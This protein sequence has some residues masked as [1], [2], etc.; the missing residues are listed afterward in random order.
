MT[1]RKVTALRVQ[2][3][4]K[5]R[6]NVFLDGEYAFAVSLKSAA[7][8]KRGQTLSAGE[9]VQLEGEGDADLAYHRA[10]R[11]LG[12]RPRSEF[13]I[14]HYL[15]GKDHDDATIAQV[16][17][18]L[19]ARSYVDD[20]AFAEFWVDNRMRFRPRGERALRA[21]LRQKGV[22]N[23]IIDAVL[24]TQDESEAALQAL[25]QRAE[26][27]RTLEQDE[28]TKKALG[29]LSRRGFPYAVCRETTETVWSRLHGD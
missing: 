28:F 8:L 20:R 9:I 10:L 18:K 21:E 15:R 1:Q 6:V 13:E 2:K 7:K 4:N 19:R 27:W 22:G 11:Y 23:R 5:E 3:R 17:E 26:R 14:T 25:E 12:Y 24:Q 29:Y 16:L